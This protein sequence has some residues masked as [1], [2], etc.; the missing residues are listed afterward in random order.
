[1]WQDFTYD[2][3]VVFWGV[4]HAYTRPLHWQGNDFK[5]L[6][7]VGRITGGMYL[8]DNEIQA[9]FQSHKDDVPEFILDYG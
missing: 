6:G 5:R 1:M 9:E 4:G 8:L 7:Y 3:G 2:M